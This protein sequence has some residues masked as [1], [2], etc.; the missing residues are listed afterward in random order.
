[1]ELAALYVIKTSPKWLDRT[2]R[3]CSLMLHEDEVNISIWYI[4]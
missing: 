4:E 1:M 2:I 3:N